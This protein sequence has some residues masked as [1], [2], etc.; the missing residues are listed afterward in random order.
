VERSGFHDRFGAPGRIARLED[1]RPDEQALRA[2]LHHHRGVRGGG[3]AARREQH[4]RQ[5][6]GSGDLGHQLV[7][8]LEILGR[9]EQL[10]V[11]ERAETPDVRRDLAHMPGRFHDVAGPGLALRPDHGRALGD[12]PEC[13]TEVRGAAHE[14]HGEGPL[15]HVVCLIRGRQHLGLVDV[16]GADR[17]E[18]LGLGEVTDPAFRHDRDGHRG[19][20]LLDHVGVAHPGDPA[21]SADVRGHPLQG[22]H[23]H[24][25]RVL[26]DLGLLRRHH[27]HD[28][29]ALEHVGHAPLDA[30]GPGLPGGSRLGAGD[31][32]AGC[33]IAD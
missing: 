4:D 30:R 21:L 10:L 16:V 26:G 23:R 2:E 7:G 12:P 3:D 19:D 17:L 11:A 28:H 9:G 8:G 18:H 5:T 15:V 14:R 20:D 25:A 32:G 29:A 6:A 33:G 22:H 31:P 13:L 24:R 27:I 1:P